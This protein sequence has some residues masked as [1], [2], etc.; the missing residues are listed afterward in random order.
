MAKKKLNNIM[1]IMMENSM[2]GSDTMAKK[3]MPKSKGKGGKGG[4]GC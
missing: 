1:S 4:R 2:K 3:A